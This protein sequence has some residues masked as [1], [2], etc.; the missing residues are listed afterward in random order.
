MKVP[1]GEGVAIHT[2]PESCGGVREDMAEALTGDCVGQVLS[3][4]RKYYFRMPTTSICAEGN[5][6]H[7]DIAS[8]GLILRGLRPWACTKASRTG[9]GRSHTRPR[10]LA[11]GSASRIRKECIG[12]GRL[13]EV[14]QVHTTW[15]AFE[16][17]LRDTA[18]GGESGGK[19]PDQGESVPAKQVPD[20]VPGKGVRYG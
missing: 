6:V 18:D 20:T 3:R 2:G 16:Q 19:G 4:E 11:L 5:T 10:K 14:G 15:D 12:D 9:T 17:N 8:D 7:G 1:Y 13:W